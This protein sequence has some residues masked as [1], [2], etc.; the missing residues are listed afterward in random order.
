M[1]S[2]AQNSAGIVGGPTG[3]SGVRAQLLHEVPVLYRLSRLLHDVQCRSFSLVRVIR[4]TPAISPSP[5][6][7][8]DRTTGYAQRVYDR[9]IYAIV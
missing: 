9:R 7:F 3:S 6:D 5:N 4:P 8:S 2:L 1:W